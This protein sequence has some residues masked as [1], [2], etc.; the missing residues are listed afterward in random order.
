MDHVVTQ[1]GPPPPPGIAPFTTESDGL[2]DVKV[3]GVY[4]L[5]GDDRHEFLFNGTLSIPTGSIDEKD[6]MPL[7]PPPGERTLPYPMQLGS[8]TWDLMP[9]F[10][11]VVETEPT[12]WG[13]QFIQTFRLGE[14]DENYRLGNRSVLTAWVARQLAGSMSGSLRLTASRWGDV[15]GRDRRLANTM[16]TPTGFGVPSA[17]PDL[18]GGKR[19]DFGVGL[20]FLGRE[21]LFNGHELGLELAVPVWQNLDGPQLETDWI[22]TLGWSLWR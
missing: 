18:R 19:V 9:G 6:S 13:T 5:H 16:P 12:S 20:N 11:I 10:T 7:P 15:H 21:G 3:G 2:G 4:R 22:V 14:N 17:N 1:G 8:G